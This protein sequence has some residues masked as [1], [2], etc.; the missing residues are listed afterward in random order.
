[1]SS[2]FRVSEC[3]RGLNWALSFAAL[4]AITCVGR[5][6]CDAQ[7]VPIV[8]WQLP[9]SRIT[10]LEPVV[11][12]LVVQNYNS[13]PAILDL[14]ANFKQGLLVTII[15]PGGAVLPRPTWEPSGLHDLGRVR[16]APGASYMR[17]FVMDEWYDFDSPGQYGIRASLRFPITIGDRSFTPAGDTFQ[18]IT[19]EARDEPALRRRCEALAARIANPIVDPNTFVDPSTVEDV[20]QAALVLSY[21]RDPV[22][23]PYLVRSLASPLLDAQGSAVLA[24]G[25][26]STPEA[27]NALITAATG[28]G[29]YASEATR[30]LHQLAQRIQ[31]P[32]VRDHIY[33]ALGEPQ[34]H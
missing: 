28:P 6:L 11:L 5:E 25:K 32:K 29:S 23:I 1:M 7:A 10:L 34:P 14:G 33:R 17:E 21:V 27:V 9:D 26:F 24:L 2:L 19:I 18:T 13:D 3:G 12:R 15:A 22:A 16:I 20:A 31:D 8:S 30:A 4:L